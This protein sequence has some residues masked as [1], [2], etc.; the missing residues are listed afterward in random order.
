M[1]ASIAAAGAF[2]IVIKFGEDPAAAIDIKVDAFPKLVGRKRPGS[3]PRLLGQ[4]FEMAKT[5][6]AEA[7]PSGAPQ[8]V[9]GLG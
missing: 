5:V 4:V 3:L 1:A 7:S 8:K 6:V 2:Q 9:A